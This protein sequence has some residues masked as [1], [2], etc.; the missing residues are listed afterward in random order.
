MNVFYS[1]IRWLY[2]LFFSGADLRL[3][4]KS[5]EKLQEAIRYEMN[6]LLLEPGVSLRDDESLPHPRGMDFV[7]IVLEVG[8]SEIRFI[9]DRGELRLDH[10]STID[11]GWGQVYSDS[12]SVK[13]TSLVPGNERCVKWSCDFLRRNWDKLKL[14]VAPS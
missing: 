7:S 2:N 10:R 1:L 3:S 14:G 6:G 12:F 8:V 4:R 5:A 11:P 13:T 9:R